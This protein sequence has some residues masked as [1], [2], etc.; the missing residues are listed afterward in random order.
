MRRCDLSVMHESDY[1][2][3]EG[4]TEAPVLP[5]LIF[6][7]GMRTSAGTLA[8][9]DTGLD[10]GLLIS[11]E[12]RDIIFAEGGPPDTHESLWAGIVEIPCDVY[13]VSVRILDKW[14]RTRAYAPIYNGYETL[15]GRTLLNTTYLC[16]RGPTK[17]TY[18]AIAES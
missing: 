18:I 15:I 11:K 14:V 1:A 9:I 16:L 13:L 17:T 3:V 2:Q 5:L 7:K 4:A 8:L 6:R 10:E 12:V